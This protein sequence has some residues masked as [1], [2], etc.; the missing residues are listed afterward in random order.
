MNKELTYAKNGNRLELTVRIFDWVGIFPKE[1]HFM[2]DGAAVGIGQEPRAVSEFED[3]VAA[4]ADVYSYIPDP[5]NIKRFRLAVDALDSQGK[6]IETAEYTITV[7]ANYTLGR[8]LL[9]ETVQA[10]TDA[11][12]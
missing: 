3:V 5:V 9:K 2:L 4:Q 6:V 7:Y 8:N 1:I 12:N 10:R 11:T